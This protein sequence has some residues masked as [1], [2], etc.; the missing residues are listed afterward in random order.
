MF[1]WTFVTRMHTVLIGYFIGT[2]T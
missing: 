2:T 1:T